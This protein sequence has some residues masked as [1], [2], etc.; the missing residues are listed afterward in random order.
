MHTPGPWTLDVPAHGTDY[1]H[2][3]VKHDDTGALITLL[4]VA[5]ERGRP[6]AE[7]NARLIAAAPEL[8]Q[9]LRTAGHEL[10][11]LGNVCLANDA[12]RPNLL[13]VAAVALALER[14]DAAIAKATKEA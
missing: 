12:D 13:D 3:G 10:R 1:L 11:E 6:E 9:A 7:A 8:L 5:S 2:A 14:C 4:Y